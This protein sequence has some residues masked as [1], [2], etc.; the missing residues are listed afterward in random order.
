MTLHPDKNKV[1]GS[2]DAFKKV[3]Q[4]FGVLSNE[5]K[6]KMYDLGYS[7]DDASPAFTRARHPSHMGNVDID[8]LT[9]EG[10]F[11]YV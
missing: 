4:A 7:T 2:E 9:P 8:D 6:R 11:N 3:S 5:E 1:R 10:M